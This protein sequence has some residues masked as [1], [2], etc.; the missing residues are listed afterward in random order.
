[1]RFPRHSEGCAA[2][3]SATLTPASAS[4]P[5]GCKAPP[6]MC[7]MQRATG[8]TATASA[9][10]GPPAMDTACATDGPAR[11]RARV[12]PGTRDRR[13]PLC[14][15]EERPTHAIGTEFVMPWPARANAIS[16]RHW[17]TGPRRLVA[18]ARGMPVARTAYFLVP[19]PT[20]ADQPSAPRM[21]LAATARARAAA[22]TVRRIAAWRPVP[23]AEP[24]TG[25]RRAR[26]SAPVVP[27]RPATVT[28]RATLL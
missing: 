19:A 23:T 4:V 17:V 16:V 15:Q 10:V 11:A 12:P 21:A 5:P 6:A 20:T 28:G 26:A 7:A 22:D 24:V 3:G 9:P 25:A 8:T 2:T 14:A 1:M 13:V 27:P 18:P